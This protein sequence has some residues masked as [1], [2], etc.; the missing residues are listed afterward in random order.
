MK[1]FKIYILA[2]ILRE[3]K[4]GRA[5]RPVGPSPPRKVSR[6]GGITIPMELVKHPVADITRADVTPV[7]GNQQCLI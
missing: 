2:K 5:M 6:I 1:N 4:L 3:V 7:E